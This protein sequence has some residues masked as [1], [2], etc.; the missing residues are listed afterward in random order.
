MNARQLISRL[1]NSRSI[2]FGSMRN[3]I[4]GE[5]E[6]CRLMGSLLNTTWTFMKVK[7]RAAMSNT[8]TSASVAKRRLASAP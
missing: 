4:L 6:G 7:G 3:P 8:K 5:Q 1:R 2:R